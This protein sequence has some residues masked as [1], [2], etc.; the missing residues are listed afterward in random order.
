VAVTAAPATGAI[1]RAGTW[2]TA[3]EVPG[4]GALNKGANLQGG[5][6]VTSLSCGSPGNCA[7]GG[8]YRDGSGHDQGFVVSERNG[9]WHT[10]IEVPG[11]GALNKSRA[12]QVSSVSCGSAG[13]CAAGGVYVDGHSHGQAFVV[14]ETNGTWRPAIKVPGSDTLNKGGW[15]RITSLSCRSAGKCAAGGLYTDRSGHQQGFVVSQA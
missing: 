12:A 4:L 9:T 6:N 5:A 1:A 2:H 7:A 10:A 8:F 15:A 11:L 3:I 13:N 14:N